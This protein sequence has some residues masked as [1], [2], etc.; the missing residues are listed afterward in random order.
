MCQ[1]TQYKPYYLLAG[2]LSTQLDTH[3]T[4]HNTC[5]TTQDNGMDEP[6]VRAKT[7][8]GNLDF[9][10]FYESSSHVISRVEITVG[11]CIDVYLEQR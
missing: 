10:E 11:D 1:N 5:D 7:T 3:T 8:H 9:E 6:F 2:Y 4:V